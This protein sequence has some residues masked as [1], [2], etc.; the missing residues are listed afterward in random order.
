MKSNLIQR[1]R[2]VVAAVAAVVVV[3]AAAAAIVEI[4]K[5]RC[6]KEEGEEG[7]RFEEIERGLEEKVQAGSWKKLMG[8]MGF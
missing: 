2:Q 1:S 6:W 8:S 4:E 5:E 3:V 7:K